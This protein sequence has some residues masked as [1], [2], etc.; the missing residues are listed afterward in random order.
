MRKRLFIP[1]VL[2]AVL[3]GTTSP[4]AQTGRRPGAGPGGRPGS[5]DASTPDIGEPMPELTLYDA[6]GE[7][8][9]LRELFLGHHT[10]LVLGC[11]T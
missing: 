4:P 7:E 10:V 11:L 9:R 8:V 3:A 6:Q 2:T 1:L 5:F